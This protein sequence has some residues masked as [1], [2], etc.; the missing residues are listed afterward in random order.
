VMIITSNCD[1]RHE[2]SNYAECDSYVPA[3]YLAKHRA[4][5][6]RLVAIRDL[7]QR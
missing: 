1:Y 4:K 3:A 2:T 7:A 5:A 6:V